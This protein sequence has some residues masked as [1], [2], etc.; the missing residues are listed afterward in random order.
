V[1]SGMF[2][3]KVLYETQ[4]ALYATRDNETCD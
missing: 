2:V 1:C 4:E 3:Q